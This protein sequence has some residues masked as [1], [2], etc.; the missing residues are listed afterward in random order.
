MSSISGYDELIDL[1]S[2]FAREHDLDEVTV[3]SL[4]RSSVDFLEPELQTA[5][6]VILDSGK[7]DD[8]KSVKASNVKVGIKFALGAIFAV[9]PALTAKG[10]WLILLVLKAIVTLVGDMSIDLSKEEAIIIFA[11]YRLQVADDNRIYDYIT[12]N[13]SEEYG[14]IPYDRFQKGLEQL[15]KIRTIKLVDGQYSLNEAVI[16]KTV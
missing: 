2:G 14:C 3:N 15:V 16:V 7:L 8:T 1:L 6:V 9:K 4:F 11:I 13:F 5:S 12:T 10:I